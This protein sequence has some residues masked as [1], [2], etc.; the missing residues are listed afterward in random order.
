MGDKKERVEFFRMTL[1]CRS[2]SQSKS[3]LSRMKL[4]RAVQELIVHGYE[5]R[6][7]EIV[8]NILSIQVE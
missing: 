6:N 7:S 8:S 5:F 4:Y 3:I 2:L 1:R